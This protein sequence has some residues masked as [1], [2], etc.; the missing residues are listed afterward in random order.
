MGLSLVWKCKVQFSK[1]RQGE[2]IVLVIPD[3]PP[4]L[5]SH[6]DQLWGMTSLGVTLMLP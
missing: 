1:N 5:S 6:G 3:L 2:P 4:A